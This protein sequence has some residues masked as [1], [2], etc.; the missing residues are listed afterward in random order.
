V[1][2][3]TLYDFVWWSNFNFKFDDAMIRKMLAYGKNL[4]VLQ[5]KHLWSNGLYRFF[6]QPEMQI[7]SMHNLN[8]RRETI[9]LDPKYLAKKYIYEFDNN[10]HWF[11]FKSEQGSLPQIF[12][13]QTLPYIG[14]TS[15]WHTVSIADDGVRS[16]LKQI[17]AR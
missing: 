12:S 13:L 5:R 15:D 2:I 14:I 1:D 6:A 16:Y 8:Q 7:W 17:L 11:A 10:Q 9:R 3:V 4:T